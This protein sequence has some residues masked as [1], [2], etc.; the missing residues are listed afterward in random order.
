M[1][2]ISV[3]PSVDDSSEYGLV[4]R[5]LYHG[6]GRLV[7]GGAQPYLTTQQSATLAKAAY[8]FG[9]TYGTEDQRE[10]D[11]N[12]LVKPLGFKLIRRFSNR[13]MSTFA[14]R[15][16]DGSVWLHIA[17]KGTQPKTLAGIRDVIS[18]MR[19][20]TG[21][22]LWDSQFQERLVLSERAVLAMN[23][24]TLTMSGHSLGGATMNDS[25]IRSR[26]LRRRVNQADSFDAGASPFFS[27]TTT[28]SL[29]AEDKARLD[30]VL[31]H[32]RMRHDIVSKGLLFAKPPGEVVTYK[33]AAADGTQWK[34][35]TGD[36][37]E[38]PKNGMQTNKPLLTK[39]VIK[40]MGILNR[41]LYA[42]GLDQFT[43]RTDL[44]KAS[45]IGSQGATERPAKRQ[46]HA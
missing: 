7:G 38:E 15:K 30:D 44:E 23:P 16:P 29:P 13:Q 8:I 40:N 19:I 11:A 12:T 32:H 34:D 4:H 41:S 28:S 24:T 42:H 37:A 6:S 5:S 18:D 39:D 35:Q 26:V 9:D 33:L 10:E 36:M 14:K 2:R 21:T 27:N 20:A 25:I 1:S 43:N 45:V 31:T 17:H 22:A 46:R 3:S